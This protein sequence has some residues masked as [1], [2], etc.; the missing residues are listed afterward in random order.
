MPNKEGHIDSSFSAH[1]PRCGHTEWYF[2][3]SDDARM[4]ANLQC[5]YVHWLRGEQKSETVRVARISGESAYIQRDR[6]R[7]LVHSM[8]LGG[9]PIMTGERTLVEF[10]NDIDREIETIK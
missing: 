2:G 7:A 10:A 9:R 3:I 5:Q 1:C 8:L 6:V 4:C